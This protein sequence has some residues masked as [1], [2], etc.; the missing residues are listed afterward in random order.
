[1][2]GRPRDPTRARRQ[3]GHRRKPDEA[4]AL[5]VVRDPVPAPAG[6]PP[7]LA[8]PEDLPEKMLPTWHRVVDAMG[9]IAALTAG[10]LF[11][12]EAFVRQYHRM[13]EAGKLV[14]DYSI[15]ATRVTGDVTVSPFLKAERDS[16]AMVLRLAEQ[17]GLTVASRMRLGLMNLQGRTMLQALND[18]LDQD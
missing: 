14:D 2:K 16:A 4:P 1:M 9:G 3:T 6:T 18:D 12:I 11:T 10:D 7:A 8:P 5:K 13:R 15:L 17:Y